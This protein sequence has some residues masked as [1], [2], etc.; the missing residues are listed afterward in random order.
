MYESAA[1]ILVNAESFVLIPFTGALTWEQ[2]V[3][4]S[5]ISGKA[6]TVNASSGFIND[7]DLIY[8]RN[9]EHPFEN[10]TMS[11]SIG[12]P[13]SHNARKPTNLFLG[14]RDGSGIY[15]FPSG[16]GTG[17]PPPSFKEELFIPISAMSDGDAPPAVLED[18]T[19][20]NAVIQVRKFDAAIPKDVRASWEIPEDIVID[21]GIDFKISGVFSAASMSGQGIVF[22]VKGYPIGDNDSVHYAWGSKASVI[23]TDNYT[24]NDRLST[25]FNPIVLTDLAAGKLAMLHFQRAASHTSDDYP[26]DFAVS[27]IKLQWTREAKL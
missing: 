5:P 21:S 19:A 15:L 17:V 10:T 9:V 18:V 16:G 1:M 3:I 23:V 25:P 4:Y 24:Q 22:E 7:G 8:I 13:T 14:V 26:Y 2:F 12:S 6:I 20:G 11:L 27:G